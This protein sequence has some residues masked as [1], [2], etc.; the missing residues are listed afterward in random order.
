MKIGIELEESKVLFILSIYFGTLIINSD[1]LLCNFIAFSTVM[2]IYLFT[3][4]IN[5]IYQ[6]FENSV[7]KGSL[8][9]ALSLWIF[10]G[11]ICLVV[12]ISATKYF[13]YRLDVT[14]HIAQILAFF[15]V[16]LVYEVIRV[17]IAIRNQFSMTTEE[18][19]D[20]RN[21]RCY[22]IYSIKL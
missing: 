7:K 16:F 19:Q 22:K 2:L 13:I 11:E 6:Q 4:D 12:F 9:T 1:G 15:G 3:F 5:F 18:F 14:I 10:C 8:L 21:A 17:F 20:R